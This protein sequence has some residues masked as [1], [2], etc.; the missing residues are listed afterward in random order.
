V[1]LVAVGMV[2]VVL[3]AQEAVMAKVEREVAV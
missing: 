2:V 1:S 3:V